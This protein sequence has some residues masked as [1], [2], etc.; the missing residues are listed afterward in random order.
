MNQEVGN[1]GGFI[2]GA[3]VSFAGC[4][5]TQGKAANLSQPDRQ[6]KAQV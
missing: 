6:G 4:P 5:F 2:G 3:S 1:D